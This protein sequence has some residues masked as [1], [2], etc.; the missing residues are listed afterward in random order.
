MAKL[1]IELPSINMAHQPTVWS[2]EDSRAIIGEFPPGNYYIGDLSVILNRDT[3]RGVWG[4]LYDYKDGVYTSC[5]GNFAMF[6][7]AKNTVIGSNKFEYKLLGAIGICSYGLC[8]DK[9]QNATQHEFKKPVK[10]VFS[11][12]GFTFLSGDWSLHII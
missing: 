7:C 5:L 12:N 10:F 9:I 2:K 6:S 8:A 4:Y 1:D 3:Y 11:N